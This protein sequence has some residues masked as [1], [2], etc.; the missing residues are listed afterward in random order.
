MLK[1]VI[2]RLQLNH[3]L[4]NEVGSFGEEDDAY[5]LA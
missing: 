1:V 3:V 5:S 2:G 4:I